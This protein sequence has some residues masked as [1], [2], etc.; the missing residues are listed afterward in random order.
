MESFYR[1]GSNADS[2]YGDGSN[3][4]SIYGDGS[5]LESSR[6]GFMCSFL[7]KV[8]FGSTNF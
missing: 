4:D 8:E 5:N 7:E 6:E 3:A 1:D 2:I